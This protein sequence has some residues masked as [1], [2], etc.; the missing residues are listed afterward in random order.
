MATIL[1][2]EIKREIADLKARGFSP[3]AI[4]EV[5]QAR[6][7]SPAPRRTVFRWVE[8]GG[9]TAV[10]PPAPPPS[11]K[12]RGRPRKPAPPPPA[13][14]PPADDGGA[15]VVAEA[16]ARVPTLAARSAAPTPA[17]PAASLVARAQEDGDLEVLVL[18]RD[19]F[20]DALDSWHTRLGHDP[21]AVRATRQLSDM[22]AHLTATIIQLRPRPADEL[23]AQNRALAEQAR[24][25]L[26]ERATKAASANTVAELTA[27]IRSL[28]Q[29]V[30]A[31]ARVIADWAETQ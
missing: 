1:T 8:R 22:I 27:K 9:D 7:P 17:L 14:P 28:E 20:A 11:G 3:T 18:L 25:S 21:A 16:I 2:P 23:Q 29:R 30:A 31:Q 4:Y 5:I 12:P 6:L 15:S 24:A 26:L 10:R 13:P 19:R